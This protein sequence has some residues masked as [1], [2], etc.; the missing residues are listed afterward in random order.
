[1]STVE[2]DRLSLASKQRDGEYDQPDRE[3]DQG[4]VGARHDQ[5]AFSR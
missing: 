2:S 1:M 3:Q 5:P 4:E